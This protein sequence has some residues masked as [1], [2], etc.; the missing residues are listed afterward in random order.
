MRRT[1]HEESSQHH[2]FYGI[3][4]RFRSLTVFFH[5][6]I[7]FRPF[8]ALY[9]NSS[10]SSKP[11]VCNALETKYFILFADENAEYFKASIFI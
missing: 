6:P 5:F 3:I 9:N 10:E 8:L 2:L 11:R 4:F 7:S 1:I